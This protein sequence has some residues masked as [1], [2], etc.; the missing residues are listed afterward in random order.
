MAKPSPEH[1]SRRERQIMDILYEHGSSTAAEVLDRMADPPSYSAVRAALRVLGDKG[2]IT[3]TREGHHYLFRPV[4][5]RARA[6]KTATRR[7]LDTFFNGSAEQAVAALIED[8]DGADQ[9]E[10]DKIA[11]LIDRARK[12]GR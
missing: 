7:L 3:H 1:L 6:G 4:V 10:L 5:T 11:A 9:E 2:H 8:A 12:D